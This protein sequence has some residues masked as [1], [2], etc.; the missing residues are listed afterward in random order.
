MG[1]ILAWA[2]RMIRAALALPGDLLRGLLGGG[3][4]GY[5]IPDSSEDDAT[6]AEAEALRR[7]LETAGRRTRRHA[8]PGLGASVHAYAAADRVGREALDMSNMPEQVAV[9]LLKMPSHQL[10]RLAAAGPDACARWAAG[11]RCGLPGIPMPTETGT[12][13]P[14]AREAGPPPAPR[15]AFAPRPAA[16]LA[17]A[18]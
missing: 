6:A 5:A 12:V 9:A 2:M 18:A 17:L 15:P 14:P 1:R 11:K 4:T 3:A 10:A 16:R 13:T 8:D 7:D